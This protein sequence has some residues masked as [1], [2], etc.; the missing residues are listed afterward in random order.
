[1]TTVIAVGTQVVYDPENKAY[2]DS[3]AVFTRGAIG[4][5]KGLKGIV[6]RIENRGYYRDYI[7]VKFAN[8]KSA[9]SHCGYWKKAK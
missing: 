7:E 3:R 2:L 6:S 4:L 9:Y 1:M 5:K 8:G